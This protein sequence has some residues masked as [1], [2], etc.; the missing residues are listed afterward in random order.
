MIIGHVRDHTYYKEC[1]IDEND[2]VLYVGPIAP[3]SK[4]LV[5]AFKKVDCFVLPS[6]LETPG[7]AAIEAA[8]DTVVLPVKGVVKNIWREG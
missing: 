3:S 8:T 7:I 4:L 6:E 5:S 1:G 2:Q